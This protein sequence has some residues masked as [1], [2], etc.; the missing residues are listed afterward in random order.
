M[1]RFA[2]GVDAIFSIYFVFFLFRIDGTALLLNLGNLA[3]L[4]FIAYRYVLGFF[5]PQVIGG[6]FNEVGNSGLLICSVLSGIASRSLRLVGWMWM[7]RGS[8]C[9]QVLFRRRCFLARFRRYSLDCWLRRTCKLLL[10]VAL[11]CEEEV[12]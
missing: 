6:R 10:V 9:L 4:I 1:D 3:H 7:Q 11:L 5:Q 8:L 12:G 2:I